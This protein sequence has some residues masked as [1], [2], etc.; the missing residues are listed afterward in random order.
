[1]RV[2]V[3]VGRFQVPSLTS[4]H[5]ALLQHVLSQNELTIV[6]VGTTMVRGDTRDPL[7]FE[8]VKRSIMDAI[9]LE[10][11]STVQQLEDHPSDVTWCQRLDK[12][13]ARFVSPEDEV[14][15]YGGRDS[16]LKCY[17]GAHSTEPVDF[18]DDSSG[19]KSRQ[20]W[21]QKTASLVAHSAW[22]KADV[23]RLEAFNAGIIH[24]TSLLYPTSYQC[25][26]IVAHVNF[27]DIV[28]IR[29][30]GC[31]QWQLPGGFVDVADGTL[32]DAALREFEEETR[33][34]ATAAKYVTSRRISDY[35]YTGRRDQVMTALF[36]VPITAQQ[37]SSMFASDDAEEIGLFAVSEI[38]A[39]RSA[40]DVMP[41][42]AQMIKD[43]FLKKG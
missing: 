21:Q 42:H 12:I 34:C 27:D 17:S 10:H 41:G 15:L 25:V 9:S 11:Q 33:I 38:A 1:M 30:P 3:I 23:A 29:K 43:W 39:M 36:E 22:P 18:E 8:C 31:H 20:V 24:G 16:F 40:G 2:G 5:R 14:T 19:T 6:V 37:T 4:G 7:P 13:I 28:M 35:R 26:D 32:E